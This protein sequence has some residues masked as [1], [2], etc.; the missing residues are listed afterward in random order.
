MDISSIDPST[1]FYL[2]EIEDD[3]CGDFTIS[4]HTF[5]WD[6]YSGQHIDWHKFFLNNNTVWLIHYND[7]EKIPS[8][9]KSQL[10]DDCSITVRKTQTDVYEISF[11]TSNQTLLFERKYP[12][13]NR[14][15]YLS[16]RRY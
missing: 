9:I 7:Y 2:P 12:S 14:F 16:E 4:I 15:F 5:E 13:E 6:P 1:S 10:K 8:N 11:E 3:F